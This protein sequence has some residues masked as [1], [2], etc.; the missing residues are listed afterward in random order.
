VLAEFPTAEGSGT[1][2]RQSRLTLSYEGGMKVHLHYAW[3]VPSW[4]KGTFQHSRIDG[5]TGRI[6][7]ESNGIYVDVRGP[8]RK[9]LSFPG[10]GDL[11]G[12]GTMTE[13]FLGCIVSSDT[14]YSNLVRARRDLE[15]VLAAY[16][17]LP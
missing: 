7:F 1:A 11:M 4:G 17:S 9:G 10:F 14:P 15:I 2:E 16:E 3:D 12:Y 13:D 5:D 6:V 8:G